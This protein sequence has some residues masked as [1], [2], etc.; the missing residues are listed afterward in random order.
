MKVK[1][2]K[3]ITPI[4]QFFG[5]LKSTMLKY[6]EESPF[7][8]LFSW[9][10]FIILLSGGLSFYLLS[11]VSKVYEEEYRVAQELVHYVDKNRDGCFSIA[12][13]FDMVQKMGYSLPEIK[14]KYDRSALSTFP[15]VEKNILGMPLIFI[16]HVGNEPQLRDYQQVLRN[17]VLEDSLA[18]GLK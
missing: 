15:I 18:R 4:N 10:A 8:W 12:E 17:Y 14:V 13:T 7:G 11:S 16:H 1:E 9:D 3:V 2:D 6:Q 5:N